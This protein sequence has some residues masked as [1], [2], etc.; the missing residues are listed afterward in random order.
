[1]TLLLLLLLAGTRLYHPET[2]DSF[3]TSHRTH[4]S[5][6]GQ[7]TYV[8]READGDIHF[9]ISDDHHHFIV[10]EIVP[11]LPLPAPRRGSRVRVRGI[12][13]FDDDAGHLWWEL[14]PV[15]Q[16]EAIQ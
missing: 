8:R 5:V 3:A 16:W 2:I 6:S 15:E 11:Y 4:V 1:M 12:R 14:N 9:R 13:R 10:C 7:V